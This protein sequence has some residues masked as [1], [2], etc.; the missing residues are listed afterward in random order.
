[1]ENAAMSLCVRWSIVNSPGMRPISDANLNALAYG[2]FLSFCSLTQR[3][4]P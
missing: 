2:F 1:M 4:Y 3:A